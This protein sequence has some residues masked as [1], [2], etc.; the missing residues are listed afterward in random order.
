[1]DFQLFIFLTV[2]AV[3]FIVLGFRVFTFSVIGSLT[4]IILGVLALQGITQTYAYPIENNT[5]VEWVNMT[6]NLLEPPLS[7]AVPLIWI[8]IGLAG[9]IIPIT[10]G[11]GR[12]GGYELG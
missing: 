7:Y 9:L 6:V 4:M 5:T 11:G 8:F 2:V 12:S 3:V 1:M 10:S